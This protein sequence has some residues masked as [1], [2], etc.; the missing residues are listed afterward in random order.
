VTNNNILIYKTATVAA[1]RVATNITNIDRTATVG[2]QSGADVSAE[3]QTTLTKE[4]SKN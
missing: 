1:Q 2:A 4:D 3:R